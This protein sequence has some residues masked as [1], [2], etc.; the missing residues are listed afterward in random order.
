V[1]EGISL[2]VQQ[3]SQTHIEVHT[4]VRECGRRILPSDVQ[5]D[6]RRELCETASY[7]TASHKRAEV[8]FLKPGDDGTSSFGEELL[9]LVVDVLAIIILH[10]TSSLDWNINLEEFGKV[11]QVHGRFSEAAKFYELCLE[12]NKDS[13]TSISRTKLRLTLS[14]R[15]TGEMLETGTDSKDKSL[16]AQFREAVD[17]ALD[18]ESLRDLKTLNREQD[19]PEQELEV[20]RIIIEAQ[21]ERLGVMNLSTLESIQDISDL[22]VEQGFLEEAEARLRRV[23]VSYKKVH[24]PHNPSTTRVME[25]LASVCA[26]MG[27]LNEAERLYT[28]AIEDY[29][30]RL[31]RD[32]PFTQRCLAQLA[33][34][35][36]SQGR[37]EE[38]EPLLVV[39]IDT[40]TSTAGPHHPDVKQ[41]KYNYALNLMKLGRR[42]ESR[43]VLED[44]LQRMEENPKVYPMNVRRNVANQLL[45]EIEGDSS[46]RRGDKP[47]EMARRL[48]DKYHLE[49]NDG[50]VLI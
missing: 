13:N 37:Y 3:P 39:A 5:S 15:Q 24:G 35:Y 4:L 33:F 22:L 18:D 32:H 26:S 45:Q 11:C 36:H 34:T 46:I 42:Q 10:W 7:V 12:R 28:E 49:S 19:D 43:E 30:T 16:S 21:K 9:N 1:L 17:A 50:L 8:R 23:L 6:A 29:Q 20:L 38:A 47:W 14:R 48:E 27:K 2:I 44:V 25:Q 31:G 40:I 41:I